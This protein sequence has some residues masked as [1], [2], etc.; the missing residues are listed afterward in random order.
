MKRLLTLTFALLLTAG[1]AMAQNA[2]QSTV[3][4]DGNT[5][6]ANV[7]QTGGNQESTIV[8]AGADNKAI[9]EQVSGNFKVK[10]NSEI[11]QDGKDNKATVS[12]LRTGDATATTNDAV[13]EQVGNRNVASQTVSSGTSS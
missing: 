10:A 7:E 8:Q 12:M 3:E 9:V 1:M 4:Q 13:I 11:T 6:T 2:N 5:N